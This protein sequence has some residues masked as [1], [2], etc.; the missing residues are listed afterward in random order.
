MA[1]SDIVA[2][3]KTII[4]RSEPLQ[5]VFVLLGLVMMNNRVDLSRGCCDLVLYAYQ[6][7]MSVANTLRE[8]KS[9]AI[10]VQQ[11]TKI[12]VYLS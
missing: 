12:Q 11:L 5:D 9:H 10:S 6:I 3:K 7:T 1:P 8:V 2:L 4:S